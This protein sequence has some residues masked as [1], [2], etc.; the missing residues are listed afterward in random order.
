MILREY[1]ELLLREDKSLGKLESVEKELNRVVGEALESGEEVDKDLLVGVLSKAGMEHVGSGAYRAVYGFDD[2]DWVI[3][4]SKSGMSGMR[5]NAEEVRI[6]KGEHGMGA[7]DLFTRL[8]SWDSKSELPTWLVTERVIN[9]DNIGKHLSVEDMAV[10][11][12]TFWSAMSEDIKSVISVTGFA[13][14]IYRT[15]YDL[16][17]V[18]RRIGGGSL[19]LGREEFYNAIRGN[20]RSGAVNASDIEW[21]G[22]WKKIVRA[23]AWT[24]PVD[25]HKGNIGVS[26]GRDLGPDA[27]VILDYQLLT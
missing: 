4:V 20:L 19:S 10:V 21:G 24:R 17:F 22:D 11:F 9:L 15:L 1:I 8:Y 26:L 6:G 5:M 13:N 7:R 27:I 18:E 2:C 25:T 23:C 12:P 16:G 3:K 14:V